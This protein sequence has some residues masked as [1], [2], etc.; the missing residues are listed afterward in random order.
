M[1]KRMKELKKE[2]VL[3]KKMYTDKK[4]KAKIVIEALEKSGKAIIKK[5]DGS[6]LQG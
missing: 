6:V 2:N 5:E 1:I 3:L 4:L